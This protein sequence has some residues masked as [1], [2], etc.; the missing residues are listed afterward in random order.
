MK[1]VQI[2]LE[3]WQHEWLAEEAEQAS[4][5]MSALLRELLTEAIERRQSESIEDDPIWGIIGLG[6]GPND[7]VTSEN[8][9]QFLYQTDWQN[10][11]TDLKV[12][13]DD[14]DYS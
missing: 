11:R 4:T 9:D 10:R 5:S 8:L 1:R 14:T 13:E 3:E 2:I 12:A 7:G 6:E